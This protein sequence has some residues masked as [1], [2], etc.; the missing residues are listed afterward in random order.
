MVLNPSKNIT[1][2]TKHNLDSDQRLHFFFFLLLKIELL[3]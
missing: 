2:E 3:W 1:F